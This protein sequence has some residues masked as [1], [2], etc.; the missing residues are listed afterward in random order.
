MI[1][2]M[3]EAQPTLNPDAPVFEAPFEEQ[4]DEEQ[5]YAEQQPFFAPQYDQDLLFGKLVEMPI[6]NPQARPFEPC[7]PAYLDSTESGGA[8]QLSA[9]AAAWQP[10]ALPRSVAGAHAAKKARDEPPP[11]PS[12][13]SASLEWTGP[14]DG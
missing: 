2:A 8:S 7:A 10:P 3:S 6:L 13:F 5:F 1:A 4:Y 14:R 11:V 12:G 9:S